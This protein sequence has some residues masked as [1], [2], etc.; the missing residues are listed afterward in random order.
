MLFSNRGEQISMRHFKEIEL[1]C[2]NIEN[3]E[4][5]STILSFLYMSK[6]LM[7]IFQTFEPILAT[8]DRN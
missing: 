8:I 1:G 3:T 6:Y 2:I 4:S 5:C 7:T